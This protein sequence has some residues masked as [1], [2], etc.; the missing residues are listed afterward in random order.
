MI[1]LPTTTAGASRSQGQSA[2]CAFRL[3]QG[4]PQQGRSPLQHNCAAFYEAAAPL[5]VCLAADVAF[6]TVVYRV[7]SKATLGCGCVGSP[8]GLA[9]CC[10]QAAVAVGLTITKGL[11]CMIAVCGLKCIWHEPVLCIACVRAGVVVIAVFPILCHLR[12]YLQA[13]TADV[14]LHANLH[15]LPTWHMCGCNLQ[16]ST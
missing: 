7:C 5:S 1:H 2:V 11:S 13:A 12:H 3:C 16:G 4:K 8:A 9:G 10:L 6:C 14:W 15:L